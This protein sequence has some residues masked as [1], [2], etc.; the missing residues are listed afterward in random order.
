MFRA[1]WENWKKKNPPHCYCTIIMQKKI[2][3]HLS[4][5]V[6]PSC[7][8]ISPCLIFPWQQAWHMN[9]KQERKK[10]W[11]RVHNPALF[12]FS[13][14]LSLSL[15]ESL[16]SL[17]FVFQIV[18]SPGKQTK[19]IQP[20]IQHT[21]TKQSNKTYKTQELNIQYTWTT[22]SLSLSL[23]SSFLLQSLPAQDSLSPQ[24]SS[25][26]SLFYY[27]LFSRLSLLRW[28]C[29][30]VRERETTEMH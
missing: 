7:I 19:T 6:A 24:L 14:F 2:K 11:S 26:F 17:C 3:N 22:L 1:T 21:Q 29:L 12:Y 8:I 13:L 25:F 27:V 18:W 9:A 23:M 20:N 4:S 15:S 5:N 30:S 10:D 16:L 28:F